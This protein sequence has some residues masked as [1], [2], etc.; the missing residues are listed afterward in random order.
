MGKKKQE[1]AD[2]EPVDGQVRS[3]R[4]TDEQF[5]AIQTKATAKGLK[6]AAFVRAAAVNAAG[7][8][9]SEVKRMK[10]LANTLASVGRS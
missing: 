8:G 1:A 6:F 4:F 7:A 3:I 5:K 10:T 2:L 9:A